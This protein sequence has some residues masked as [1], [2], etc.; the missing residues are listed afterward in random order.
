MA[1][2]A[3][4]AREVLVLE[5]QNVRMGRDVAEPLQHREC[6]IR[7][8]HL[9]REALADQSGQFLLVIERIEARHH[10]TGAMTEQEHRK[11][12]FT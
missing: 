11:A 10:A 4:I 5:R 1:A 9:E 8:R 7:R 12:R 6:K 3:G 2:T